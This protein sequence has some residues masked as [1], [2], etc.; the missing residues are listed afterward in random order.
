L[1]LKLSETKLTKI[2]MAF[3]ELI[4]VSQSQVKFYS[5]W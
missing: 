1:V 5:K 4:L 3:N 2:L